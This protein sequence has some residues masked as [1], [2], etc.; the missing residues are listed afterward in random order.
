MKKTIKMSKKGLV[1][2]HEELTR[3]LKSGNK[4]GL[5]KELREQS[6]ELKQLKKK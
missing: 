2:E 3:V 6:K 1:R 4:K 5:K